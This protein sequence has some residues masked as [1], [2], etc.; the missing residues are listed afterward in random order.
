M[1]P[2]ERQNLKA[3]AHAMK[4]VV[5][6]GKHVLS[7][8]VLQEIDAALRAHEIIKVKFQ[9]SAKEDMPHICDSIAKQLKAELVQSRGF[10]ATFYRKKPQ[11]K[12]AAAKAA[13]KKSK[14]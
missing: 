11:Q 6:V 5:S 1:T 10:I 9:E 4:P 2:K 3:Q 8:A 12:T 13:I 14:R 7:D